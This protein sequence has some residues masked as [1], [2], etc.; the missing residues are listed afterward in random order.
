MT[1]S[2]PDTA[3]FMARGSA[4]QRPGDLS[5]DDPD[6]TAAKP[7]GKAS[8]KPSYCA[9]VDV[10]AAVAHAGD[11]ATKLSQAITLYMTPVIYLALDRFSGKGP[12]TTPQ[13]PRAAG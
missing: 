5:V 3:A 11:T 12:L 9:G 2:C 4:L 8:R 10:W 7:C 1:V 6:Q 13:L